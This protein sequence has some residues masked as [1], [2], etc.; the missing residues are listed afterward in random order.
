MAKNVYTEVNGVA[1]KVTKMYDGVGG[2]A[3]KVSKAYIGVNGVA[4]ACFPGTPAGVPISTFD[5]GSTVY[6]N[7]NGYRLGFLIVHQGNPDASQYDS[8][9]DGTWLLKKENYSSMKWD[10]TDN[11]YA[12]SNMHAYLNGT[13]L[14]L[15]ESGVRSAIKQVKIPYMKGTGDFGWVVNG[16]EGLSTKVFLLSAIEVGLYSDY[17]YSE[18]ACLSYFSSMSEASRDID[19]S[20]WLRTPEK[21]DS[22]DVAYIDPYG[23]YGCSQCTNFVNTCR[24]AFILPPD[25]LV[26][27]EFNVIA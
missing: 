3:R 14:N 1:R 20:W 5:V 13:F 15:L 23:N 10:S 25:V 2:V 6:M 4:L 21:Y 11:D 18:G 26:D 17:L 12:N 27:E 22:T 8:S 7:L 24:P 19:I 9:C 16:S